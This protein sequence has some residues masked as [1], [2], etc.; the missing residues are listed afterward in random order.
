[1]ASGVHSEV[2]F[3]VSRESAKIRKNETSLQESIFFKV[4]AKKPI[5]NPGSTIGAEANFSVVRPPFFPPIG[6]GR[7]ELQKV[8]PIFTHPGAL[9]FWNF[10]WSRS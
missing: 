8:A 7:S 9:K 4:A 10:N 6:C 2:P 5:P 1:L 3:K